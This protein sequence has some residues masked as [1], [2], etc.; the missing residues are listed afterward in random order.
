MSK[1]ANIFLLVLTFVIFCAVGYIL[2]L[3]LGVPAQKDE[4][5]GQVAQTEN[6]VLQTGSAGVKTEAENAISEPKATNVPLHGSNV[7]VQNVGAAQNADNIGKTPK[8]IVAKTARQKKTFTYTLSVS[9][10]NDAGDPMQCMI[11]RSES[12]ETPF[13]TS[14]MKDGKCFFSG[15]SPVKGGSYYVKVRNELTGDSDG[16]MVPG[17]DQMEK[18]TKEQLTAYINADDLPD[19][20][21]AHFDTQKLKINYS[22][23]E[24]V[25]QNLSL[26]RLRA[27]RSAYNWNLQVT[28]ILQYDSQNRI[29]AFNLHITK[30]N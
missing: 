7:P 8:N 23:E 11:Y 21:F 13:A 16:I 12:S 25:P 26:E 24:E 6:P 17:F 29:T 27:A 30:G 1:T 20:F 28:E 3:P 4:T 15:I 10:S 5:K 18:W 22:G 19:L 14:E 2:P 9:A